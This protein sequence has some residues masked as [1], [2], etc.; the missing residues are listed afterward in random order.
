MLEEEPNLSIYE[1]VRVP[2]ATFVYALTP[3]NQF[4]IEVVMKDKQ[5][6]AFK[7]L[8]RYSNF[9]ALHKLL[10]MQKPGAIVPPIPPKSTALKG[11]VSVDNPA[12]L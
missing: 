11:G 2:R 10:C 3:Y 9:E 12:L 4:E 6:L 7:I 8:H 1:Y 5:D